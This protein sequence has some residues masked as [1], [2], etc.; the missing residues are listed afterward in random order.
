MYE[1]Y[2][3]FMD[4]EYEYV[5]VKIGLGATAVFVDRKP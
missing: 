3:K 2:W 1:T 5:R 4:V